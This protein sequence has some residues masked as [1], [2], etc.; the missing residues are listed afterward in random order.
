MVLVKLKVGLPLVV[1]MMLSEPEADTL[2]PPFTETSRSSPVGLA[3][4]MMV[5]LIV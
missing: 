5:L 3:W 1:V 4:P 2:A